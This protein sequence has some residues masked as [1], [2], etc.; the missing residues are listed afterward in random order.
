VI[1]IC[2]DTFP[3]NKAYTNNLHILDE[4][5]HICETAAS[6]GVS[7]LKLVSIFSG[8]FKVCL[9]AEGRHFEH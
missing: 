7:E 1:F 5:K 6:T 4:L 9:R 3:K 8:D 2:G